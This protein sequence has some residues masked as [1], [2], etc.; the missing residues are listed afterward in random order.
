MLVRDLEPVISSAFRSGNDTDIMP[1]RGAW[2]YQQKQQREI[3]KTLKRYQG[4]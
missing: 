4:D 1:A 3:P 2:W